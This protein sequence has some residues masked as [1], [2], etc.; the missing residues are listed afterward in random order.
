MDG[1]R[2]R[3][4]P[5]P[6]GFLH[7]G[8]VRT[9]L[10]NWLLARKSG[11]T[12]I[13]RIEDTDRERS[14]RE[15]FDA[16]LEDLRWLG[17]TWDEGPDVGGPHA[18]YL[19]SE[20]AGTYRP[21]I[22]R[23]LDDGAAYHCFCTPEELEA[24]KRVQELNGRRGWKYDR[25]C[26]KLPDSERRRLLEEGRPAA[27]RFRIP[28]GKTIFDDAVLGRIEFDNAELDD[29]IIARPDGT[30]TYNFAVVVDDMEMEITHVIRGSDHVT[31]TPRQILLWQALGRRPP[32]FGHLPLVLAE[33]GGV[34]SKRRGAMPIGEYRRSGYLP[35]ALVNYMALLGWSYDGAEEFFS[36][37]ELVDKFDIHRVSRKAATFDPEKLKWMNTQWLKRLDVRE[38]TERLLP[39]LRSEQLVGSEPSAAERAW[40]EEVVG[41]IDDRLKT[42]KDVLEFDWFF[43]AS[44]VKYDSIAVSEV[45]GKP[46]ADDILAGLRQILSEAPDFESETLER[47]IRGFAEARGLKAGEVIQPLRV[48]VC[49][50]TSSPGIFR[51]LSLLGRGRVLERLDRALRLVER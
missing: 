17:L 14:T 40:I 30:P 5:S 11:G 33:D 51:T 8:V 9:A 46:G 42:L 35:E 16:I 18:P 13:L 31:N 28:E 47:L 22:Q 49:G 27:V 23:L 4:A 43:L 20:R 34:M 21:Y 7:L 41:L 48:G 24:R 19:Q 50:K 36:L 39:I 26:L 3:F 15:Y 2:V 25:R 38:R 1:V 44:D 29:L 10:F 12:F 45:L 6:T 37:E 32:T